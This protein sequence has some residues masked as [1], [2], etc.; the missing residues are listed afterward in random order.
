MTANMNK[1]QQT[2][3][4]CCHAMAA[5]SARSFFADS[6]MGTALAV[7]FLF[8]LIFAVAQIVVVRIV[9]VVLII[10][11]IVAVIAINKQAGMQLQR[12][13]TAPN[14]CV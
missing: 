3:N 7:S 5:F 4:T 6:I 13:R 1:M 8:A 14:A 12:W 2:S 10:V 11:P 9:V